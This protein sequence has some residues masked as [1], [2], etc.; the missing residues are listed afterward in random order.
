MNKSVLEKI[1]NKKSSIDVFCRGEFGGPRV[2]F[3]FPYTAL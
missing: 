1:K 3:Y 2:K